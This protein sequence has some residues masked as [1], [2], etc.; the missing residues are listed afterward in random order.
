[1]AS[2]PYNRSGGYTVWPGPNSNSFVAHVLAAIPE[3]GIALPPT[4]IGKDWRDGPFFVGLTPSRTGVQISL[5]GVLG[6][7]LGWV[8]GAEINVLGAVTGID[9]RRP[10][11]KLPGFGRIGFGS[12][13]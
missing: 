3:A 4:A 10:A 11:I 12:V 8:E 9:V 2:Y 1:M 7:S 6:F 5:A 13:V